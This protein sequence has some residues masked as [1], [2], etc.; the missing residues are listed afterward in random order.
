M[1]YVRLHDLEKKV[2]LFFFR[3][4]SLPGRCMVFIFLCI[5]SILFED[6]HT[7]QAKQ[8]RTTQSHFFIFH[9]YDNLWIDVGLNASALEFY[10]LQCFFLRKSYNVLIS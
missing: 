9:C 4:Y 3:I 6:V 1:K 5:Y 7:P 10:K 2:Y 8:N